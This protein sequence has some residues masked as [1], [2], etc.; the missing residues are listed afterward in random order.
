LTDFAKQENKEMM[1]K[2]LKKSATFMTRASVLS[3][4]ICVLTLAGTTAAQATT[5]QL[6]PSHSAVSFKVRHL[7]VSWVRGNL[8]GTAA[9]MTYDES[10]SEPF[11]LSVT[12]DAASIDTDNE[13]RD[14]HLRDPDFLDVAKFPEITFTSKEIRVREDGSGKII[15]E[16]TLHGVTKGVTMILE[17]FTPEITDPW[18][19]QRRGASA[20]LTVDRT[21]YGMV[22]NKAMET[23][24][25][26]VGDEVVIQIDAEFISDA[27]AEE[28][29]E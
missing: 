9:S 2:R 21:D 29:A 25:V 14:K 22:F 12:L 7:M 1:L 4:L 5:Y 19:K 18:G 24:G 17:D 11:A 27:P 23:G 8:S 20:T 26:V 3:A 13:K 10:G 28:V 16:L 6:D 15:G